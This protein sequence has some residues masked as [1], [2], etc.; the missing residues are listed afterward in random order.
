MWNK[1]LHVY[2]AAYRGV[3]NVEGFFMHLIC[4]LVYCITCTFK[5]II[6]N[7]AF[8]R[9]WIILHIHLN[10]L[11]KSKVINIKKPSPRHQ[12]RDDL[13]TI[14]KENK[15]IE[16]KTFVLWRRVTYSIQWTGKGDFLTQDRCW[17]N[18]WNGLF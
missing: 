8:K 10:F 5:K 16:L 2:S 17:G 11:L 12:H 9:H 1:L 4:I 18:T 13:S 15:E 3:R 14:I 7:W 6:N